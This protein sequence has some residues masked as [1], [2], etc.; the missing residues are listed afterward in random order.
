MQEVRVLAE[1][2]AV[3][4]N[5][6]QVLALV[7]VVL[8][9]GFRAVVRFCVL[10]ATQDAPVIVGHPRDLLYANRSIKGLVGVE[11]VRVRLWYL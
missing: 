8:L 7:F 2:I 5:L 9:P 11:A 6:T 10:K 4:L 3:L 1:P